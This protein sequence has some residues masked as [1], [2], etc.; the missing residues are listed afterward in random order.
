VYAW[1]A[2]ARDGA[3]RHPRAIAGGAFV[4][5][6][7]ICAHHL[8]H[9]AAGQQAHVAH[10]S[11]TYLEIAARPFSWEHLFY[12]KPLMTPVLERWAGGEPDGIAMMQVWLAFAA[13][14]ALAGVLAIGL[15]R[16]RARLGA[17]AACC[18]FVL[19]PV[20]LGFTAM[21]LS[22]SPDDSLRTLAIASVLALMIVY[23]G[24]SPRRAWWVALASALVAVTTCAWL[25]VRDTNAMTC[26][27]AV[28]IAVGLRPRWTWA[29][30]RALAAPLAAAAAIVACSVVA[31]A[32]AHVIPDQPLGLSLLDG[33]APES[34]PRAAF[35][36]VDDMMIRVMTDADARQRALDDGLPWNPSLDHYVGTG[37]YADFLSDDRYAPPRA[38]ILAHG[39]RAYASWF[40]RQ[41]IDRVEEVVQNT[42]HILTPR[43]M[44]DNYYMPPGWRGNGYGGPIMRT[45]RGATESPVVGFALM[46]GLVLWW[47]RVRAHWLAPVVACLLWSGVIGVFAAYY[48]DAME[49]VRHAWGASQQL[50]LALWLGLIL[51][52]DS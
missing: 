29:N 1:L 4:V 23:A 13:W 36:L 32:S 11:H 45:F 9:L 46:L 14:L 28:A 26:V 16:T 3:A 47:R 25:L 30:R 17:I 6:A 8:A 31:F 24:A 15:R 43:D 51:R 2:K 41:P 39:T 10:D 35:P 21:M 40:L 50:L 37:A 12:P 52:L 20:R 38:W 18:A 42:W 19:A 49:M 44:A 34:T 5:A 48:G 22:E 27:A 7:A 33:W